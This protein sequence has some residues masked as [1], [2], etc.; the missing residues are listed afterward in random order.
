M[1][2]KFILGTLALIMFA[3]FL[4]QGSAPVAAKGIQDAANSRAAILQSL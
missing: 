4:Y 3:A 2:I 1:K